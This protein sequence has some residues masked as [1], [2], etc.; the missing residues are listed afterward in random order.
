MFQNDITYNFVDINSGNPDLRMIVLKLA[1]DHESESIAAPYF[2]V[3][4]L[5]D[6]KAEIPT[7]WNLTVDENTVVEETKIRI[8]AYHKYDEACRKFDS[9]INNALLKGESIGGGMIALTTVESSSEE[10]QLLE[11]DS[12]WGDSPVM[13]CVTPGAKYEE[14]HKEFTLEN[15]D[16]AIEFIEGLGQN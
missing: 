1:E 13:L 10:I 6:L 11:L 7:G 4:E 15:L 8:T 3:D 2:F 14:D 16:S 9:D 5:D 12:A